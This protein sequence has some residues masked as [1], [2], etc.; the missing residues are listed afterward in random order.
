[1]NTI[2]ND[3]RR[4]LAAAL[5]L[6]PEAAA[7]PG[8]LLAAAPLRALRA[9]EPALLRLAPPPPCGLPRRRPACLRALAADGFARLHLGAP[10]ALA[11]LLLEL[12]AAA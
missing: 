10:H 1:M 9:P 12:Q 2:G 3:D 11:K 5:A 8:A 6:R 7:A 4:R